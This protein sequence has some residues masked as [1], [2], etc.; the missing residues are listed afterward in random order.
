MLAALVLIAA[1]VMAFYKNEE[2]AENKS[3]IGEETGYK[4]IGIE[5]GA[6]IMALTN[7][8]LKDYGLEDWQLMEGSSAAMVAELKKA[9]SAK[10][11]IIITGWS[12]HWKFA[13]FEL[14]YLE[15]PKGTYG[16]AEGIHT[17]ARKGL[18]Q[19]APGAYRILDQFFWE[20]NDIESVMGDIAKGM[21][22]KKAAE[23][24]VKDNPDKV[25]Q[26]TKGAEQGT[27]QEIKLV[28]VAWDTEIASTNVIAKVLEQHGY[29]VTMSQ[30]E[31]GPMFAGVANGSADA[32]VGAWLPSTHKEYHNGYKKDYVDLGPNLQGT[33]LGLVVPK[34]VDINSIEDLK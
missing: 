3:K 25:S 8:A 17:I 28:Y 29:R 31:V 20:P 18:E 30:V 16:E 15:D 24:W 2:T 13:E 22:A 32:M 4:I 27:G 33:K 23:K 12:P 14:K 21:D 26:W 1:T 19:D 6:G 9:Y 10:K 5:P 7:D 34:Y 11:P